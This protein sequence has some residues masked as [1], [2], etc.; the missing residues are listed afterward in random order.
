LIKVREAISQLRQAPI[1][2]RSARWTQLPSTTP[3]VEI[4]GYWVFQAK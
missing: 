2:L 1:A 3:G 4:D